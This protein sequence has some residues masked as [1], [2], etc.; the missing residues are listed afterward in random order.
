MDNNFRVDKINN[1]TFNR[2][3]INKD[4]EKEKQQL[5]ESKKEKKKKPVV[6][7]EERLQDKDVK[8]NDGLGKFIDLKL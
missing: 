6:S 1:T 3:T 4:P 8:V 2:I 7:E 5:T